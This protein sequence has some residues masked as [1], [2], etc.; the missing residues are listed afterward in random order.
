MADSVS[1]APDVYSVMLENARVRVL[2]IRTKPGQSSRLHSHPD[3]VLYAVT[4]CDW[5]LGSESGES[6][7]VHLTQGDSLFLDAVT[8][9]ALDISQTGSHA[10]AI[11]L[12]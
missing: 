1:V 7:D 3:M 5:R 12:K 6:V 4:N 11:E 10:I 9:T 2:A 8:H